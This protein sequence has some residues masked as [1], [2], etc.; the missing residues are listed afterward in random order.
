MDYQVPYLSIGPAFFHGARLPDDVTDQFG[1][2][3][4]HRDLS[5]RTRRR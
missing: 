1:C 5:A 4:V 2:A 3:N